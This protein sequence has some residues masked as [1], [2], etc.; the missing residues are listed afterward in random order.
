MRFFRCFVA[1]IAL[2][3][4]AG[5]FPSARAETT[6][7]DI[8]AECFSVPEGQGFA[9]MHDNKVNTSW[10]APAADAPLSL[11]NETP[12]GGIYIKWKAPPGNWSMEAKSD[13]TFSP[14]THP[15]IHPEIFQTFVPFSPPVHEI[16]LNPAP[17]EALS[18]AEINVL[19]EGAIPEN[20]QQWRPPA[21]KADILIL[22]AHPDDDLL[23]FGG[24]IPYYGRELGYAVQTVFFTNPSRVRASEALAGQ[25]TAGGLHQPLMGPFEDRKTLTLAEGERFWGREKILAYQV[26]QIRRFKPNIVLTHDLNGEYG[27]GAHMAVAS[28]LLDAL[29]AA[30]DPA[31]FPESAEKYGVWTTPKAYLHLY[32]KNKIEMD[33]NV[34]IRSMGEG[35]Q[36][37]IDLARAGFKCHVSQSAANMDVR[38]RGIYSS[39]RFGLAWTMVGDDT[40]KNDFLENISDT[41]VEAL[42]PTPT[43]EPTPTP[44]ATPLPTTPSPTPNPTPSIIPSPSASQET[45]PSTAP[46]AGWLRNLFSL[47]GLAAGGAAILLAVLALSFGL[48]RRKKHGRHTKKTKR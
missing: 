18:I 16:R 7:P 46:T 45:T 36:R 9:A 1:L 25:W 29:P 23:Y 41:A 12:I 6:A 35:D 21:Q 33:W 44:T 31:Q 20:V 10:T 17:G 42:N 37:A 34:I 14:V 22:A 39:T 2:T 43:P 28:T 30:A 47:K 40:G 15:A 4:L 11:T 3:L 48:R 8:T 13:G 26:E 24:T 19:G 5:V 32:G 27:H 38:D